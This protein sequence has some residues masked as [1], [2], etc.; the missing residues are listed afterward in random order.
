VHAAIRPGRVASVFGRR[1]TTFADLETRT[2]QIANGLIAAVPLHGRIAILDTNSD[3][4]FELLFGVAKANRVLVPVHCRLAPAELR[5]IINDAS[6]ELLFVGER[7]LDT[8]ACIRNQLP[9]V[10]RVIA[11]EGSLAGCE[12][13]AGWRDRQNADDPLIDVHQSDVVLQVYTSGTTGHPRGA[14]LTNDNLVAVLPETL[15]RYGNW[16]DT[17][18]VLVCL[19]LSHVGGNLWGLAG[20]YAG[21]TNVVL[22][23]AVPVEIL[24]A[25]AE[26]RVTKT[27]LVPALIRLLL[28]SPAL[29]TTD[30][31]SLSLLIYAGSPMPLDLLHA[32]LEKFRCDVGQLYGLT[33]TAGGITYLPPEDHH[34]RAGRRLTSCGRPLGGVDIR[35][36]DPDGRDLPAGEIGEIVCRSPQVMKGYWDCAEGTASALQG[37]WLHTGDAGYVDADGYLYIHDRV[38]D[39]IVTGAENVYPA[40]VERALLA[41]AAIADAAVVGVPDALWGEAV[42]AFVV[43][44]PGADITATDVIAFTRSRI[45]GFKTPRSVEFVDALPRNAMG[46]VLRR[47]LRRPYWPGAA[48]QVN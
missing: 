40:E 43:R 27:L 48:R 44:R 10:R 39:A 2:N 15:R 6:A 16:N 24:S 13:Y 8:V 31:S 42:K 18:V 9:S 34:A 12:A 17:D 29:D 3:L 45:A 30:L 28:G 4:F 11:L 41:H 38:N 20:F 47:D 5:D 46:K 32:A 35:I 37:G 26:Y 21:A 19:P 25:I 36:V 33:E 1:A 23:E 7:F 14:Q 22:A